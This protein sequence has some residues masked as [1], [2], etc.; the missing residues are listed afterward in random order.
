MG[1]SID[2]D[3]Q[4]RYNRD[5]DTTILPDKFLREAMEIVETIESRRS[6]TDVI[7][8]EEKAEMDRISQQHGRTSASAGG[9]FY[10][11]DEEADRLNE[12][13]SPTNPHEKE[14]MDDL[15]GIMSKLEGYDGKR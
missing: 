2:K 6:G 13:S 3:A 8:W 1:Q 5:P 10:G 9:S 15:A 12:N 7:N 11:E 14:L 4:L